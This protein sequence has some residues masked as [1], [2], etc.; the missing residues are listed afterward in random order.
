[1]DSVHIIATRLGRT[2]VPVGADG[3]KVIYLTAKLANVKVSYLGQI[4]DYM[5]LLRLWNGLIAALAVLLGAVVATGWGEIEDIW[6]DLLLG[7]LVVVLF[8]GVGNALNDYLDIETDRVA[9]PERPLVKEA[10]SRKSAKAMIVILF[11]ACVLVAA[12]LA[13]FAF[14]IVILAMAGIVTYELR[15]KRSGLA[16]NLMISVLVGALFMFGGAIA[17]N[18]DKTIVLASLAGLATLGR[19]IVKDIEDV[20][21]DAARRTLPKMIGTRRAGIIASVAVIGAVLLSP[22]PYLLGHLELAYLFFVFCA[23]G[24]FIVG[25]FSQFGNPARGQQIFKMAMVL[26]LLAFVVGVPI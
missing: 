6:V 8:M 13:M 10:I 18:P 7:I 23:D 11:A 3:E 4:S 9:H 17:E 16:G 26:A 22:V 19:E 24:I 2:N 12:L 20:K 1:M 5:R 25:V 15:L 21:G 14:I